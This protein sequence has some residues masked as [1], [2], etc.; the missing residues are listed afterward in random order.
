MKM[1]Q[2]GQALR[3]IPLNQGRPKG[4][5]SLAKIMRVR[6]GAL[7]CK[8]SSRP[9]SHKGLGC[10]KTPKLNLCIEI[11]CRLRQFEEAKSLAITVG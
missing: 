3:Q 6:N 2:L 5:I 8:N 4:A 9:M 1:S 10:V 7:R 11:L